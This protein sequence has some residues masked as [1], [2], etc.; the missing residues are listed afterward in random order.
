[1]PLYEKLS[2]SLIAFMPHTARAIFKVIGNSLLFQI[3]GSL[4]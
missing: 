3:L 2:V 1:V 4:F